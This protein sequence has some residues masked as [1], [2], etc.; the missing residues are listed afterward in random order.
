MFAL[1]SSN[2]CTDARLSIRKSAGQT[3]FSTLSTHG[4]NLDFLTWKAIH[5]HILFPLLES[6]K[7]MCSMASNERITH[8][9]SSMN[10]ANSYGDDAEYII[11]YSRN[12][13]AKQWSETQVLVLGGVTRIVC[14]KLDLF[15][16]EQTP[17]STDNEV[18]LQNVWSLFFEFIYSAAVSS[19]QEV[20]MAS[21]KC[22][23]EVIHYFNDYVKMGKVPQDVS[24]EQVEQMLLPVWRLAWQTWYK[25]GHNVG[26]N[27]LPGVA[28]RDSGGDKV[29]EL[30]SLISHDGDN[31]TSTTSV[32]VV[33]GSSG[34]HYNQL[35]VAPQP[36]LCQ[37][38]K[39]IMMIFPK[40]LKDFT[41][42]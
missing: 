32:P 8:S 29:T 34:K 24:A 21:L 36:F 40:I 9:E 7:T 5:F 10:K 41:E 2:L 12:T 14:I 6:V 1:L 37:L 22:F 31:L 11:H 27:K 23:N 39:P 15:F 28:E 20:A 13:A 42:T 3:L 26:I 18:L 35:N 25:I 33:N 38:I 16:N 17:E 4:T 19:N 30:S